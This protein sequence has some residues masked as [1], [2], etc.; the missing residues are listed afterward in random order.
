MKWRVR[1]WND[2]SELAAATGISIEVLDA[3]QPPTR[4]VAEVE[5]DTK[6]QAIVKAYELDG[7]T[8]ENMIIEPV[9]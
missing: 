7:V 6:G 4:L 8:I 9:R 3:S 2:W 5:A 1:V